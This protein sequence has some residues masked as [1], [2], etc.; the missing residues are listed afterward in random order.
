MEIPYGLL[1]LKPDDHVISCD[2][3]F[4]G[5]RRH[6]K[7]NRE[8]VQGYGIKEL[9]YDSNKRKMRILVGSSVLENLVEENFIRKVDFDKS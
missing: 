3:Y 9:N 1:L 8:L 4:R 6:D 7:G 5:L 2:L